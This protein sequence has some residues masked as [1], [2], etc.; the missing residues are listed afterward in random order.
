MNSR[1]GRGPQNVTRSIYYTVMG[2]PPSVTD[3][4]RM[5]NAE[6]V[7]LLLKYWAP[8]P[9]YT[10]NHLRLSYVHAQL[11]SRLQ[12]FTTLWTV[13]GKALLSTGFPGKN[14]AIGCHFLFQGIFPTQGSNLRLLFGR[15]I[16]YCWATREAQPETSLWDK[17]HLNERL[18]LLGWHWHPQVFPN[19]LCL[20]I[21][22][23]KS[24]QQ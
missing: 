17:K 23:P 6:R 3:S 16:L 14:S 13:A 11:L 22:P 24:T 15:W 18:Y 9:F 1:T 19:N 5:K 20:I 10:C 12:L 4:E 21:M 8:T 7:T 2:G